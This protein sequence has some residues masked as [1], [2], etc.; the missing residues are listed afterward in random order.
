MFHD[1]IVPQTLK[2]FLISPSRESLKELLL[3]NT[4][5]SDY[6]DFKSSWVEWTKLAKHILA[7]SNSGGGCLILGVRQ[8]D[9]GSLTLRGLT[10]EDFYDKADVDNKLQHLLPSYLTYRTEDYLFQSEVDPLL[11][12]KRFQALIIEYDP[13]YVPF[14]SV[15]TKGELRDGAI[16]VRQ[17]TKTIEA[18]NEHL[19]EII[20]KKVHLNGYERSM[21]SLEEHLSDLRTLLKEF[22]SSADVRYRQYVEEWIM[23]KKQRIEKVLG[24]DTFP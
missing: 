13:R 9:D 10:D 7:I 24:L 14:T 16:Y 11:H 5:E 17:G 4:G 23:R 18:G 22:H 3:N 20:M 19:V 6:V 12:S 1:K 8:E 21:K 15:V 2:E